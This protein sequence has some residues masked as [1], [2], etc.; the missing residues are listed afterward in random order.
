MFKHLRGAA[1]AAAI[2]LSGAS[3]IAHATVVQF[4][5]GDVTS[6]SF[7]DSHIAE[8]EFTDTLAFDLAS[9]GTF[10]ASIT[11][12]A[13]I[14]G[15]AGDIDFTSVVLTGPNG[16]FDFTIRNNDN[17]DG[18]TDSAV[19]TRILDAGS[20]LLT[21]TGHSYGDAQYGG[22]TSFTTAAVPEPA[23]WM[24]MLGGFGLMGAALRSRKKTLITFA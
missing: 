19:L 6:G 15:A 14:L 5:S 20:Y 8:G 7:G 18:L 3:G 12:A 17:A 11:S 13:T 4:G 1:Y 16:P 2:C 22:N 21:I 23:S 10:S 9:A 24:M